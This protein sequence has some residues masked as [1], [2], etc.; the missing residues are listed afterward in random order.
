[1]ATQS[2]AIYADLPKLPGLQPNRSASFKLSIDPLFIE[3]LRDVIDLHLSR[4]EYRFTH[5]LFATETTN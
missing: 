2:S 1:L 4:T 3:K 5:V